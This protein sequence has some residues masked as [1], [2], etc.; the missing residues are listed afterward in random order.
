MFIIQA[1]LFARRWIVT[2]MDD[3]EFY[4]FPPEATKRKSGRRQRSE[5]E[6]GE[7]E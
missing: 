3:V 7:E 6:N 1:Q 2:S 5:K 4:Y